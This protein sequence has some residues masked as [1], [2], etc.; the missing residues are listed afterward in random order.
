MPKR[1][2]LLLAVNTLLAFGVALTVMPVVFA[3]EGVAASVALGP[4]LVVALVWGAIG[5]VVSLQIANWMVRRN[6]ATIKSELKRAR[7]QTNTLARLQVAQGLAPMFLERSRPYEQSAELSAMLES[8]LLHKAAFV[9]KPPALLHFYKRLLMALDRTPEAILEIGVKGGGSTALWKAIFPDARVVGMDL[10]FRR[11][12]PASNDGV[13]YVE[14]DQADRTRLEQIAAEHGPFDL[15][16][17]D[18]SHVSGDQAVTMRALLP[19]VYPGG[20]YVVEDTHASLKTVDERH[21]VDYGADIWPDFV[22]ALLDRR[23]HQTEAASPSGGTQLAAEIEPSV[24]D[25][26]VGTRVLALRAAA[27][28]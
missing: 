20:F 1:I 11:W 23:Q 7:E 15:V 4:L 28:K 9:Q 25:L 3:P 27:R 5:A 14:G 13:I 8:R 21:K 2:P 12:L 18:G 26:I 16:I 6:V 19:H 10:K 17:D 24:D 22:V